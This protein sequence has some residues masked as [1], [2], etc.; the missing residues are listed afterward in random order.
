LYSS[1]GEIEFRANEDVSVRLA[2]PNA[3][4][5][6]DV[7]R[8]LLNFGIVSHLDRRQIDVSGGAGDVLVIRDDNIYRF[9]AEIGPL[10]RPLNGLL[11]LSMRLSEGRVMGPSPRRPLA[12]E[13]F[14][15]R[16][17]ALTPD[18]EEMVYDLTEP[19]THSFVANG[20]VVHNCGE[21]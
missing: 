10:R 1:S 18:G 21:Q 14:W 5:L 7:Q 12:R 20:L 8:L 4:L 3:H 13:T 6:R 9:K 2:A 19:L 15:A 11:D 16:F 17:E